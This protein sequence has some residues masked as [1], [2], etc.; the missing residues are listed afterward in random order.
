M[1]QNKFFGVVYSDYNFHDCFLGV[2]AENT[3]EAVEKVKRHEGSRRVE[4]IRTSEITEPQ[5]LEYLDETE[6]EDVRFGHK[7]QYK[8][9]RDEE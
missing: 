6:D 4:V 2:R 3:I 1:A 8:E 9:E 7:S 5:F